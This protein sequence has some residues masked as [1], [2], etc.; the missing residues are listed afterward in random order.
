MMNIQNNNTI[1]SKV[2]QIG[3]QLLTSRTNKTASDAFG[4][5]KDLHA[6]ATCKPKTGNRASIETSGLTFDMHG[7]TFRQVYDNN[8]DKAAQMTR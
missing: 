1:Q 7:R 5:Q 8:H 4:I 2:S 3:G 6:S